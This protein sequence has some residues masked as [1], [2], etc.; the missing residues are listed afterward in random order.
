MRVKG[1]IE[2]IFRFTVLLLLWA[3]IC[4]TAVPRP[5]LK[6]YKMQKEVSFEQVLEN[7]SLR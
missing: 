2:A 6:E 4:L 5:D 7:L 1:S 3:V